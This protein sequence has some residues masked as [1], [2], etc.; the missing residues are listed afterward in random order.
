MSNINTQAP[1]LSPELAAMM[2]EIQALKAEN[3]RL[4]NSTTKAAPG[5]SLRVSQKGAISLYGMGRFPITLYKEQFTKLLAMSEEIKGFIAA[6]E[7][8]LKTKPK[9]EAQA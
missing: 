1:A 9:A 8:V 7:A 6:N 4:A 3:H 2:A 5:L